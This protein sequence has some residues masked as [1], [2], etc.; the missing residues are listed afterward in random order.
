MWELQNPDIHSQWAKQAPSGRSFILWILLRKTL[1]FSNCTFPR[2]LNLTPFVPGNC[3]SWHMPQWCKVVIALLSQAHWGL[4]LFFLEQR[5]LL[6]FHPSCGNPRLPQHEPEPVFRSALTHPCLG[7]L[8]FPAWP[9]HQPHPS[10]EH[11]GTRLN[12]CHMRDLHLSRC[13]PVWNSA[14]YWG[15]FLKRRL[16]LLLLYSMTCDYSYSVL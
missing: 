6:S 4:Q 16:L 11:A 10:R 9:L 8:P 14:K 13:F 5:L 15:C 1:S 12:S 2:Q 7:E 3:S